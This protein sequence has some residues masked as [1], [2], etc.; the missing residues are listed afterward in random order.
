[1]EFGL[2]GTVAVWNDGRELTISS[3]QQRCVLAVLLLEAGH[4]VPTERLVDMLWGDQ[5]IPRTARNVIQGCVSGLRRIIAE[6]PDVRLIHKPPGYLLDI[7]PERID[8]GQFRRLV[9]DAGVQ[10]HLLRQALT[11]WRAEPLADVDAPGLTAVKHALAE[12]RLSVLQDCVDLELRQ[13]KH[14][15]LVPELTTQIVEH[16]LHERFHGQLMLALYRAGR[17]GDAL[18]A[19]HH[20]RQ[21]LVD[22]VGADPGPE[23]RRLHEQILHTDPALDLAAPVRALVVPRQLPLAP[24]AFTG[25]ERELTTLTIAP[26]AGTVVISAIGGLGGI[27]KTW[28]A[29]HWAH[30][31]LERFPDGQLFVNLEGF[32][33][34]GQPMPSEVAVRGFLDALGVEPGA[35]PVDPHAQAGLYRSL[36]TGKR[37]L[38]VLDNA[39]D[40]AHV[41]PLLPGTST[42]TV[43]I[44]SRDRMQGLAT[45]SGA[46]ILSLDALAEPEARELLGRRLGARRME[47]EPDAIDELL[48][49]CAGLPLALGIVAGR[50]TTHPDFPLAALAAELHDTAS[51]LEALDT[52]DPSTSLAVVLSWSSDALTPVPAKVFEL[53]GLAPGPDISLPAVASLAALSTTDARKA[54]RTLERVSLVDEYLP[55]R[56]RMHDLIHLYAA[57]LAQDDE[58]AL[59]RLVDF[60]V[61]ATIAGQHL[62]RPHHNVEI[63]DSPISSHLFPD[64]TT[65]WRWFEA[66]HPNLLAAQQLAAERA[67][68]RAV[69]QLSTSLDAIHR[70]WGRLHDN[71][72][73]SQ[74]GLIAARQLDDPPSL[75]LAHQRFGWA[76][77]L[78]GRHNEAMDHFHV[79][80]TLAKDIGDRAAQA[81]TQL[82]IAWAWECQEDNRRALEHA[83]LALNLY[84]SVDRPESTA[85]ALGVVGWFHALL[86]NYTEAR[87]HC[88]ASLDLSRRH[89][90]FGDENSSIDSLG[91]IAHHTG[92]HTEALG[93]YRQA[94]TWFR[95]NANSFAEAGTLDRLGH[96]H[97]A[98]GHHD[99]ARDTWRQA[100]ELYRT[101]HRTSD[102]DRV[103]R[104]LDGLAVGR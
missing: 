42:C 87:V 28:L 60:Y 37:M 30:R 63:G 48:T 18:Q 49:Y 50:A 23:L 73:T 88:E 25:R 29:L 61:H 36:V 39:R 101:Q 14:T 58:P 54:M 100:L 17:A 16:P 96:T 102:A 76:C 13:G 3:A 86:G 82:N 44:T 10:T 89:A 72:T 90:Y 12:E 75:T 81:T 85:R 26:D 15:E 84:R 41:I 52:G 68:H 65:A 6:E 31:N 69:W 24:A 66:E 22:E 80:L 5:E 74:A 95:N 33:P 21:A 99:Q 56:W 57:G 11:L 43:L 38:I 94:L 9:A 97:T 59:R 78:V 34:S 92:R 20:A 51:R 2:L 91:Y 45:T 53:L 40:P 103:Q 104:Q 83:I 8:L 93:Y 4:V 27:G 98:L 62:V 19:F 77:A 79:A 32:D 47:R 71:L 1:M 55:G 67:W 46:R 35:I 64:E 70:P 7:S